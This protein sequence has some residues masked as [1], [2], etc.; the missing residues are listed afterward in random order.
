VAMETCFGFSH[1]VCVVQVVPDQGVLVLRLWETPDLS[2]GYPVLLFAYSGHQAR[3]F[4]ICRVAST[5]RRPQA[6]EK[7]QM[8]P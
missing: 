8:K 3:R 2:P 1:R 7:G 6:A 5:I 4:A